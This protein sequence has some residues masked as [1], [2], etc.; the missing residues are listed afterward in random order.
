MGKA[1]LNQ[2]QP[3]LELQVGKEL[4]NEFRGVET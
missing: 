3:F 1:G 2:R 4:P